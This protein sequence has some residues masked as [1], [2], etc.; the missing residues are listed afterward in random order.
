MVAPAAHR[1]GVGSALLQQVIVESHRRPI[2]TA[3]GRDNPPAIRVYERHGFRAVGDEEVPPGIW[4][5][6]FA[7]RRLTQDCLSRTADQKSSRDSS[8]TGRQPYSPTRSRIESWSM[9][10]RELLG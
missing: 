10:E 7:A 8:P 3:T 2:R 1:R 4:I 6:R 5:T 9:S